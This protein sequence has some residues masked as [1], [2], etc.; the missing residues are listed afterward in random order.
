MKEMRKNPIF[1]GDTVTAFLNTCVNTLLIDFVLSIGKEVYQTQGILIT[2]LAI[3]MSIIIGKKQTLKEKVYKNFKTFMIIEGLINIILGVTTLIVGS[4][5]I[6]V[7]SS[8]LLKPFNSLQK[9]GT[10]KL[11]AEKIKDREQFD[12]AQS[13]VS[14]YITIAG[15]VVGFLLNQTIDGPM[16]FFVF[17]MAEVINNLFY[18]KAYKED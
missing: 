8:V 9:L 7:I 5:M 10:I 14:P 2:S 13:L 16:S 17:C 1:V 12:L 15:L 18:L 11:M 3:V 4:P 6:Y